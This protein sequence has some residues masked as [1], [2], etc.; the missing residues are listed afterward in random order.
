MASLL[1]GRL[2]TGSLLVRSAVTNESNETEVRAFLRG[3]GIQDLLDRPY[4]GFGDL[5]KL[6]GRA[7]DITAA[8][9]DHANAM[10]A[11]LI[12]M[13]QKLA[14][15]APQMANFDYFIGLRGIAPDVDIFRLGR[16]V[17]GSPDAG[18]LISRLGVVGLLGQSAAPPAPVL[19][20]G[21]K[22]TEQPPAPP[23]LRD[24]VGGL[25]PVGW[26][27]AAVERSVNELNEWFEWR[28]RS[29]WSN[30]WSES[31]RVWNR[32]VDS[33]RVFVKALVTVFNTHLHGEP[34]QY[35]SI[36]AHLLE[37]RQGG[38]FPDPPLDP[39]CPSTNLRHSS[40]IDMHRSLG[41]RHPTMT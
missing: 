32:Q 7:R 16:V 21:A 28:R 20:S 17:N 18:D 26:S 37:Q 23:A 39:V 33:L 41:W 30:A 24:K 10:Q 12:S 4:T 27:D 1:A 19:Q 6:K 22:M 2:L 31:Q 34:A 25:V 13:R 15:R 9:V 8:L 3:A 36:C 38:V 35:Q 40:G 14:I 11:E 29:L 5:D